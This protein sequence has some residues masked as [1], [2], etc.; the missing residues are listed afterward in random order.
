M[1]ERGAIGISRWWRAQ[2][3]RGREYCQMPYNAQDS[4]AQQRITWPE[5][6]GV[7][8]FRNLSLEEK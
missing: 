7:L 6:S 5:M 4:A 8:R 3:S 1:W 2:V